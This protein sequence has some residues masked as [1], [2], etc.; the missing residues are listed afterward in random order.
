MLPLEEL[1]DG[2]QGCAN[3]MVYPFDGSY[4]FRLHR[5]GNRAPSHTKTGGLVM[6]HVR[7]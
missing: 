7:A 3:S 2:Q 1:H 5:Q 6:M 4:R